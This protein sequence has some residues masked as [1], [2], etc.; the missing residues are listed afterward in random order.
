MKY[1]GFKNFRR[2]ENLGPI[3][4]GNLTLLSGGNNSGKSTIVKAAM[5][6]LNYLKTKKF[7]SESGRN[8][9][10]GQIE[11]RKF[12][13]D[14]PNVHVSSF[15][16]AINNL[17]DPE[18]S[19]MT[20]FIRLMWFDVKIEVKCSEN[21][22]SAYGYVCRLNIYDGNKDINY[23]FD[24]NT[25]KMSITFPFNKNNDV[26]SRVIELE[27]ELFQKKSV[28]NSEKDFVLVAEANERIKTIEQELLKLK[29]TL[30][31]PDF[32]FTLSTYTEDTNVY[33]VTSLMNAFVHFSKETSYDKVAEKELK[34]SKNYIKTKE[35]DIT[36]SVF[37]LN[38]LLN[39]YNI[40]FIG[41]HSASQKAVLTTYDTSDYTAQ[42]IH[43]FFKSGI[44]IPDNE[45][46]VRIDSLIKAD[47]RKF[48]NFIIEKMKLFKVGNGLEIKTFKNE[49]YTVDIIDEN[50]RVMPLSDKGMGSIQLMILFL[51]IVT[52]MKKYEFSQI[53][54][55]ILV[56]EPEQNLHPKLQSLLA[57]LFYEVAITH[58][59][60][61]I[62]ETHSEYL[63]RKM[64]VL[65]AANIKEN[66]IAEDELNEKIKVYYF[67]EQAEPYSLTFRKN[68]RFENTFDSGFF[69]EA[70]RWNRELNRLELK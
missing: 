10:I 16:R 30:I 69:D 22:R 37:A 70:S 29:Q 26:E 40:E 42:T 4:L 18:S 19:T 39:S 45:G 33:Y 32:T 58:D 49:S 64:Q 23:G 47:S 20:F 52:M 50:A 14:I 38:Y 34:G 5:L 51:R 67:P 59:F 15:E 27:E 55:I 3:D 43:Q 21:R 12:Y 57:D 68:G 60:Q 65:F 48:D 6:A 63:V 17:L 61:L 31:T 66:N 36:Q 11:Y 56:E 25:S 1:I 35:Q 9:Y 13:F 41:A 28:I 54:P 53:K 8:T 46:V 2:F 62:V 7:P 44:A 24:F